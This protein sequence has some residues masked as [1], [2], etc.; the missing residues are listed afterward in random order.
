MEMITYSQVQ[1]LVKKIP[2]V[3]LS[4]V[5]KLLLELV[6]QEANTPSPQLDLLFLP[7]GERRRIMAQQAEQMIAHYQQTAVEWQEWQGGDFINT[8]D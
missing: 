8:E 3:K 2:A 6:D 5:Y 7:L 1:E 4:L